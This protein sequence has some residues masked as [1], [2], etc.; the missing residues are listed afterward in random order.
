[1]SAIVEHA[2]RLAKHDLPVFPLRDDKRPTCPHGF[3]DATRDPHAVAALWRRY[4]GSLIGVPTGAFSGLDALDGDERHGGFDWLFTSVSR[5]PVTRI[6]ATRSGGVHVLFHHAAGVR[7]TA[8]KIAPGIDIRGDGGYIV[9][10]PT[11]G[12]AVENANVI[13]DWP[14]K[15]LELIR[16]APSPPARPIV[17]PH[18]GTITDRRIAGFLA[19]HLRNVSNAAEGTKHFTLRNTAIVLGGHAHLLGLTD[20]QLVER[21][22]GALPDT[23]E[24]WN[25]ARETAAWGIRAGRQKPLEFEDRPWNRTSSRR[26]PPAVSEADYGP[27]RSVW[28]IAVQ[29]AASPPTGGS[30]DA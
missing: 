26:P 12:L 23:V 19:A 16:R 27:V 13:A 5:L 9:W 30:G 20:E 10:W 7:N 29:A 8:S 14:P 22:I 4:P 17:T 24:D 21:L 28:P 2:V 18:P 25:L 11:T 15:L 6:H 3:K 1:M